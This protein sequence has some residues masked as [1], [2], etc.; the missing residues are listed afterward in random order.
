MLNIFSIDKKFKG[1]LLTAFLILSIGFIYSGYLYF[2]NYKKEYSTNVVHQLSVVSELKVGELLRW[3]KERL[4]DAL[5]FQDNPEFSILVKKY[6]SD[7]NDIQF[8]NRIKLLMNKIYSVGEYDAIFLLSS[9]YKQR[10]VASDVQDKIFSYISQQSIDS[11]KVG[12]TVFEDFYYNEQS[13]KIY[14]KILIPVFD[15]NK[16]NDVIGVVALRIDPEKYLYPFIQRW[17]YNS[18]S[19]ETLLIRREGNDVVFINQLRFNDHAALQLRF[20]IA[21]NLNVPAV[22][23]VLGQEGIVEGID[24]RGVNVMSFIHAVPGTAWFIVTKMD[25][26]EIYSSYRER[27]VIVVVAIIL[28]VL[29]AGV[30][31]GFGVKRNSLKNITMKLEADKILYES[32]ER[33]RT[34]IENIGEGIAFVDSNERFVFVNTAAEEIFGVP[35]GTLQGMNLKTFVSNSQFAVVQNET[36]RRIQKIKSVYELHIE[37]PNGEKR[38][39]VVTA[40]PRFENENDFIGTY[41]VFRDITERKLIEESLQQERLLLR[42]VIDNIPDSIYSKDLNFRKTLANA[43]EVRFSGVQTESEVIGKNDFDLYP[44]EIAEKFF[45][46]DQNVLRTGIPI[47]NREEFVLTA[48][49]EKRWLITSKLP[50]RN[51][52]N[53]IIGLVG[54]GRDNTDRK[55]AEESLQKKE[56]YQRALLDNFPFAV[57]LKDTESRFLAVNTMFA[58]TF[59]AVHA[60]D[61]IGKSDFDIAS[62]KDAVGYVADDRLVMASRE[63]K[64]VE[65]E[66][67]EQGVRKWF[68]T[69][70]APVI[71]SNKEL[72]GTVGFTRDISERKLIEQNLQQSEHFL[73]ETQTIAELG[74][75]TMDIGTGQW[76]SSEILDSI[77]G[78]TAEYQK[79]VEGWSSLI[80]PD[81]QKIMTEYFINE[82]VGKGKK[83]NKEYKIIRRND[84]AERWVH[85]IGELKFNEHQHPISMVGTIK[86][87]TE[88]KRIEEALKESEQKFR[89]LFEN[90]TEGVALHEM[91]YDGEKA[92][93]YRIIDINPAYEKHTGLTQL[94]AR[95]LLASELYGTGAPPYFDEFAR[96]ALTGVSHSFETF[97]PPLNRHF[98]IGVISPGKGFF[99]TVFEDITDRKVKEQELQEKNSELERFT[100][101][102]SHDLKSPLITIKGFSGGL[103]KDVTNGRYDRIESDLKRI[104]DAADKMSGLLNDLLE[105]SRIGRI[106]NPPSDVDLNTLMHEVVTILSGSISKRNATVIVQ[107][108]LPVVRADRRRLFEVVQNLIENALKFFGE[109]AQPRIEIGMKDNAGEQII[110]VRDNGKGIDQRYHET[111]FGLFNKLDVSSEGTGIGLALAR[112]IIDVHGGRL[113]VESE[114]VDRGSTFCFTLPSQ[115]QHSTRKETTP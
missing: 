70:K 86:D 101:T 114:G 31:I 115:Q 82:V 110:F 71:G 60:D 62:H 15:V 28:L 89:M 81:W 102:V 57:W 72:L 106:V 68:E 98:H 19:G 23:A 78:I 79:S 64:N 91:I 25:N 104:N 90:M 43:A 96:V 13:K 11:I 8:E 51:S 52:N 74:T 94:H 45:E 99:A 38:S 108:G 44:K 100:Y 80:H 58:K 39:I 5:I 35:K 46:D 12:K 107:E 37:R 10:I 48:T 9:N 30:T 83:F 73:R 40:V 77:F 59:G 17:P 29:S 16:K 63:K 6:L 65:E 49:G 85:G 69:Y 112:R 53:E 7:T 24:Y 111:I 109:Q 67:V 55:I 3:R 61:L 4:H 113:W 50:L 84:S 56:R 92:I 88:R 36:T 54:I 103:I 47:V 32:E 21:K 2:N 34:V 42:T 18:K 97:F 22:K 20:D 105:L 66:I 95:G 26:S 76:Q 1:L 33:F 75:Y 41:G 14:L 87:I 93:D 27:G